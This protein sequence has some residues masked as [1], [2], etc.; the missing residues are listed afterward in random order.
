MFT[1]EGHATSRTFFAPMLVKNDGQIKS[2]SELHPTAR[3]INSNY[4]RCAPHTNSSL[5][6]PEFRKF[7]N[8]SQSLCGVELGPVCAGWDTW[9]CTV[10]PVP[11]SGHTH[12]GLSVPCYKVHSTELFHWTAPKWHTH[13]VKSGGA[14]QR[15]WERPLWLLKVAAHCALF[16]A[17]T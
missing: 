2:K 7:T 16:R 13:D 12:K 11:T 5:K 15:D 4:V 17:C 6:F 1:N 3:S 8:L 9:P 14:K 10:N